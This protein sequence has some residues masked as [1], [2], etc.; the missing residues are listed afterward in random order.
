MTSSSDAADVRRAD[1]DRVGRLEHVSTPLL[2]LRPAA[3]RVLELRAV[4]LDAEGRARAG[5]DRTAHQ[6]V[7][8][9]DEVGGQQ[10]L[11]RGDVRVDVAAGAPPA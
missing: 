6:D 10:L 4:R 9:E 11:Q 5:A 7:I 1:I 8:R 3:H 2:E